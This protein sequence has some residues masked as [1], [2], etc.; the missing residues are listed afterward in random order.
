MTILVLPNSFFNY[1]ALNPKPY[2]LNPK[3]QTLAAKLN[4]RV[5]AS[6]LTP[7]RAGKMDDTPMELQGTRI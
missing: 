4:P 2:T 6:P 1:S 3:P 7:L 5:W